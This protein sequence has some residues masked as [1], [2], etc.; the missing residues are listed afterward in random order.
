MSV[1]S[2]EV[3]GRGGR[4]RKG[5]TADLSI[6]L[7]AVPVKNATLC[8]IKELKA[9]DV[10][11]FKNAIKNNYWYQLFIGAFCNSV[12]LFLVL[13][14][15]KKKNTDDLPAWGFIGFVGETSGIKNTNEPVYLYTHRDFAISFNGDQIIEVNLTTTEPVRLPQVGSLKNIRF[16]WSITWL[17]VSTP[18]NERFEKYLDQDFFEHK[19]RRVPV[20]Q[21]TFFNLR[22]KTQ[23]QIHWFSIFNSFMMVIF[24]VGLVIV[25]LM[26]TLNKDFA[27]YDRKDALADLDRDLGD[28]YGWKQVHA[29]VFR[30]PK[31]LGALAAFIGTGWQLGVLTF[32]IILYTIIGDLYT[33]YAKNTDLFILIAKY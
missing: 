13:T 32:I 2:L 22:S 30:A 8:S 9:A 23:K 26:R 20:L 3:T 25:I 16:S 18:F 31:H 21:S 15:E 28:E 29:D 27:R 5:S 14:R 11:V 24:L 1:P 6:A 12:L 33:E 7:C 10:E 4:L 19:V 17:P